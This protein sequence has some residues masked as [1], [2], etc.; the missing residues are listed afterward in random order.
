MTALYY[1][2]TALLCSHI[3]VLPYY[4]IT[5]LLHYCI[6]LLLYYCITLHCRI[7]VLQHYC[8]VLLLNYRITVLPYYCTHVLLPLRSLRIQKRGHGWVSGRPALNIKCDTR[9][10]H[11]ACAYKQGLMIV[12]VGALGKPKMRNTHQVRSLHRK[13]APSPQP[14]HA[15][16]GSWLG[17]WVAR[18][19]V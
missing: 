4:C 7:T 16:K 11:A 14:A 6:T 3:T 10:K 8:G 15:N 17:Q 1:C 2:V 19:L 13:S 12:S 5:A 18:T 9:T